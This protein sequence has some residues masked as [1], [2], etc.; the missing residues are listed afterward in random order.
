MSEIAPF[1]DARFAVDAAEDNTAASYAELL[2]RLSQRSVAKHFEAYVDVPWDDPA[3]A[4]DVEDPRFAL[5]PSDPLGGTDWYREQPIATRARIG[6]HMLAFSMKR[7]GVQFESVLKRGLLEFA[8]G[9]P[10]GAP[11]FRYV[12]HELTEEAHHA[13]MFQEFVNRTG[14]DVPGLPGG[15]LWFSRKIAAFG[16]TFPEIFFF[17]VLAGEDSLDHL[18]RAALRDGDAMH[19]LVRRIVQIHV[20]EEARHLSFARAYLR[21]A[22][23]RLSAAKRAMLRVRVPLI[24]WNTARLQAALPKE[25]VAA[26]GI[27]PAVVRAAYRGNPALAAQVAESMR[28]LRDLC[29]ELG[30]A[31]SPYDRLWRRLG[32]WAEA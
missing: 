6:V 17:F 16:R 27:P 21:Q 19:P 9:L 18:Q 8:V 11:E 25:I 31:R 14:L 12:Y 4:I 3:Y 20:I 13:L 7:G 28:K 10:N 24:L 26:Y 1:A 32:L 5:P 29:S 30:L 23:P 2:A 15:W 22:V